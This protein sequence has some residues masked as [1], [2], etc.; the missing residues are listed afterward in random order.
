MASGLPDAVRAMKPTDSLE[1]SLY[2]SQAAWPVRM[3]DR[4]GGPTHWELPYLLCLEHLNRTCAP[5]GL[6]TTDAQ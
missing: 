6:A 1:I 5:G 4:P 2:R 3:I